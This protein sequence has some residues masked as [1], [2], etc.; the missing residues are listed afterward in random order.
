MGTKEGII[1]LY[2]IST[3]TF[4]HELTAHKKEIWELAM[5]TNP[6]TR[7]NKGNLLIASCSSDKTIK[8]WTLVQSKSGK[9]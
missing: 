8:F 4:I 6:Q 2:D 7:D 9:M 3:S 5:H 1:G